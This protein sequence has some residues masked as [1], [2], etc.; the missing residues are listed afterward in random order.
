[1]ASRFLSYWAKLYNNPT[2]PEL[3]LEPAVA[4][5]GI[6]YRAQHPMFQLGAILDFAVYPDG[7]ARPGVA[8]EVD[9]ESHRRAAQIKKDIERTAKLEALGWRVAR[10]TN[11]EALADPDAAVARMM[12]S[13]RGPGGKENRHAG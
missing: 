5:L 3:A 9:G 4:R 8:L 12:A 7:L 2:R 13:L 10:C 1:M 11:E 6:P